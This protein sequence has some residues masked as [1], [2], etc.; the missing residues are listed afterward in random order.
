MSGKAATSARLPVPGTRP[1]VFALVGGVASGK[2]AVSKAF[3]K[4]GARVIDA[5]AA[6]H[7]VLK[8]PEVKK[9]LVDAFGDDV[10]DKNGEV[11]RKRLG[12]LAFEGPTRVLRLNTI[13]HPRIRAFTARQIAEALADTRLK[14]VVLDISLLLESK[15][16]EGKYDVLIFVDCAEATREERAMFTR[17]WVRGEVA[18]RQKHQLPLEQ[19]RAL[20]HEVVDNNGTL[21]DVERQVQAIWK[22]Y[23]EPR[24]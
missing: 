6:G 3:E 4:L 24:R 20:A 22:K 7:E 17:G 19:K 5:D 8:E 13:T 9:E 16:Y 10:I 11:S 23:V 21:E 2:S 15:N 1:V 14:A 12:S 18:R